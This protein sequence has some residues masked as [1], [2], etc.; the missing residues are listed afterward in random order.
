MDPKNDKS[1]PEYFTPPQLG[2]LLG[3]GHNKVLDFIHSGELRATD[4]SAKRGRPR[5]RISRRDLESFLATRVTTPVPKP[6]RRPRK[7][8]P[9]I[10]FY[11]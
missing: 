8:N 7:N 3:I 6:A 1:K 5:W 11:S 2:D 10:E 9:A 4:L